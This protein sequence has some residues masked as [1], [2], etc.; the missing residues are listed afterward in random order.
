MD[1]IIVGIIVLAAVVF[2]ARSF[3]KMYKG[4]EG[5]SCGSSCS[6]SSKIGCLDTKTCQTGKQD[7]NIE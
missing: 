4:E 7:Y 2:T 3:I 5:C 1:L 6:C